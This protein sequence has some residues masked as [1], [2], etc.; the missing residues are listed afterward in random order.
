MTL[1]AGW[2]SRDWRRGPEHA[3]GTPFLILPRTASPRRIALVLHGGA[4]TGTMRTSKWYLPF[5]RMLP[6]ADAAERAGGVGSAVLRD[7]VHGYNEEADPVVDA[8]WALSVLTERYPGV[9]VTVIGHSMGGRV[10]LELAGSDAV[11]SVVGLAPWIPHQY[12]V[13]DFI[14]RKTLLIHG[15]LDKV[16]DPAE[17]KLLVERI[18]NADG[19][20][21][22]MTL[23]DSHA[24]LVQAPRWHRAAGRFI[25][26]L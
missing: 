23:R 25:A 8:R 22:F 21:Q 1:P 12:D 15:S 16:T 10:A 7:A 20:A 14:G 26:K 11:D 18:Q 3:D 4:E 9:P 13:S 5:L 24:M 19:T 6:F 17:S 2:R